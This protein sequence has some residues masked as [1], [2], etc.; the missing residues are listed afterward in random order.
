MKKL[1]V[2]LLVLLMVSCV[3]STHV[4]KEDVLVKTKVYVGRYTESNIVNDKY[5]YVITTMGL[6]KLKENPEI[7]DSSL[8]YVRTEYPTWDFHPDIL[9][10]M[11][12]LYFTWYGSDKE[13]MVYNK[14]NNI[15]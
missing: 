11:K 10:Q 14:I 3:S 8:C 5:T 13:Y 6:F 9:E 2:I 7:P 15:K 1:W 4:I 12:V